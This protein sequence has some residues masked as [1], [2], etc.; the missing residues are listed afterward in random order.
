MD[1]D[2]IRDQKNIPTRIKPNKLLT[3]EKPSLS[4]EIKTISFS[5][6]LAV[7]SAFMERYKVKLPYYVG[8]MY[9]GISSVQMVVTC[10]KAGILCFFGSAG[11]KSPELEQHIQA[12]QSQLKANQNYGMCMLCNLEF[13][14]EEMAI[15][16]LYLRYGIRVVEASAYAKVTKALVYYRLK[17]VHQTGD[18]II[19]P[20]RIVA[21]V[22]RLE[23]AEKFMAPPPTELVT[24]LLQEGLLN[25]EEASLSVRVCM[26]SEVTVEAD[27]G[28][29]TDQGVALSVIPMIIA[30]R[31][32]AQNQFSF[33]EPILMG[34]AGGIG[35]PQAVKAAFALGVDYVVTGSINQCTVESGAHET[36]KELLSKVGPHD[37]GIAPAG[38]MFEIGAKVQVVNKGSRFCARANKL[39]S[40]YYQ[41]DS[42]DDLPKKVIKELERDYFGESLDS[43]WQSIVDYKQGVK[44]K[45]IESA[46]KNGKQK[47]ALILKSYFAKTTHWTLS[48]DV[49]HKK[50]F[51][52]HCGPA[53]GAFNQFVKGTE[54]ENWRHRS[55]VD[56]AN[57]MCDNPLI[58]S[59][60]INENRDFKYRRL[61]DFSSNEIDKLIS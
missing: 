16:E 22:S 41:Y 54:Y 24:E 36:V 32:R 39:S 60:Y 46:N 51:Q 10:S 17:G 2:N 47:L 59:D 42:V 27:S 23:V 52:I 30:Q 20:N 58:N 48:G 35:T 13:P 43:V 53:M 55:V 3:K 28:G 21:K 38:D 1:I 9:R 49:K 8:S 12:I 33:D 4:D 37:M 61:G 18:K 7:S 45:E 15:A 31:D 5:Q 6:A 40:L 25:E 44:A 29:H 26:A 57:V 14:Q 50:D 19:T 11:F 56:I 34:A